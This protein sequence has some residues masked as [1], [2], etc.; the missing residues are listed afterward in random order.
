MFAIE[1]PGGQG[2]PNLRRDGRCSIHASLAH[3]G[4]QGCVNF[5]C[6]GAGQRVTQRFFGGRSWIDDPAL[7]EPMSRTFVAVLRA[8]ETLLLLDGANRF[9]LAPADRER[10]SGLRTAIEQAGAAEARLQALRQEALAFLRTLRTYV[11]SDGAIAAHAGR[12]AAR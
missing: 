2:C 3:R 6:H 1:K 10:L 12:G 9:D 7:T 11:E 8:H 4:F 5:D